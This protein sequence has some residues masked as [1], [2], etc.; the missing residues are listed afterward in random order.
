MIIENTNRT[1]LPL[2]SVVLVAYNEENYIR[3]TFDSILS[4]ETNFL[5]EIVCH[6]DASTDGTPNIIKEYCECYPEKITAILQEENQMKNGGNIVIDHIYPHCKG[7]YIAYCDADDYWTD[8]HKLQTQVDFLE[9]HQDYS[10]CFHD[11]EFL[12]EESGNIVRSSMG[13]EDGDFTV[14]RMILWNNVPQIG[15]SMFRKDLAVKRPD[16]FILIG[17]G[18]DSMRQISDMPLYIY[19][20]INGKMRYIAK[21]MSVWRRRIAGTWGKESRNDEKMIVYDGQW[22]NFC[23]ELDKLTNGEYHEAIK[24]RIDTLIVDRA[25]RSDCYRDCIGHLINGMNS[26]KLKLFLLFAVIFPRLGIK[27]RQLIQGQQVK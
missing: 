21:P 7:K 3:Q 13:N 19:L 1:E 14:E 26:P 4:Q 12:Y 27:I 25:F 17:G 9:R 23:K 2:V 6:D 15:A 10:I 5:F 16:L 8:T 11:Y 22:M 24:K 18:K 20:G